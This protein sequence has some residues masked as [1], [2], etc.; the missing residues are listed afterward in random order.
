M[1]RTMILAVAVFAIS[2]ALRP[3]TVPADPNNPDRSYEVT[4]QGG[5]YRL[6]A[7]GEQETHSTISDG[8]SLV[9]PDCETIRFNN[10][11]GGNLTMR[12]T[13][14]P[15]SVTLMPE[16]H[17][18]P[19]EELG[20]TLCCDAHAGM[21]IFEI[22]D[23]TGGSEDAVLIFTLECCHCD[24]QSDYDESTFL[25]AVDFNAMIDVLFF[26]TIDPQD[27]SCP[28]TRGDFDCDG[29]TDPLDLNGLID[30]LFFGGAGPCDPCSP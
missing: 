29:F 15:P 5:E 7:P 10:Q 18:G 17:A 24:H 25:D 4:L 16:L 2:F 21:W 6:R 9:A 1:R 20:Y 22:G 26:G 8:I 13:Q 23:G 30:H 3:A 12:N 28:T 19:G 27:P 11:T 14:S